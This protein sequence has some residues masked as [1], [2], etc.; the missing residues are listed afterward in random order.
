MYVI[1]LVTLCVYVCVCVL[2]LYVCICIKVDYVARFYL[3]QTIVRV[4]FHERRLQY[5]EREQISFWRNTRPGERILDIGMYLFF[6]VCL[7]N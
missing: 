4:I 5:M 2:Y 1:I 7:I 6:C 3:L